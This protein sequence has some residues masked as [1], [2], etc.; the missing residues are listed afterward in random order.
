MIEKMGLYGKRKEPLNNLKVKQFDHESR[1]CLHQGIAIGWGIEL[2]IGTCFVQMYIFYIYY[3]R[4]HFNSCRVRKRS[5]RVDDPKHE[6][7][8]PITVNQ[9][10]WTRGDFAP[11]GTYDNA[12][13]IW[14]YYDWKR[15]DIGIWW[16]EARMLP[17]TLQHTR[18]PRQHC[19]GKDMNYIFHA[20]LQICG[21]TRCLIIVYC[22]KLVHVCDR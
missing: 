20:V 8:I 12:W 16:V 22:I 21:R 1:G 15:S 11:L 19:V 2:C 4:T 7:K 10:F 13:G 17:N 9:W 5:S 3:N 6:L 14:C 18:R